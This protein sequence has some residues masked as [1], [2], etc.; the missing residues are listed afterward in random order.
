[1]QACCIVFVKV[2]YLS[3]DA[4]FLLHGNMP[5]INPKVFQR[6]IAADEYFPTC[7]VTLK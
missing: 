2:V 6:T 7:S 5:E 4:H 1:M 3:P